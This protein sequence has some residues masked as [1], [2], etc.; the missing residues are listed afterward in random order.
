MVATPRWVVA[1]LFGIQNTQGN[2]QMN[3]YKTIALVAGGLLAVAGT[4]TAAAQRIAEGGYVGAAAGVTDYKIAR[5]YVAGASVYGGWRFNS[6]LAV[7]ASYAD[8]G[9][10]KQE[11][12][13]AGFPV[14]VRGSV[15]RFDVAVQG[16]WP[17][18]D[19]FDLYAKLGVARINYEVSARTA[20]NGRTGYES[21]SGHDN[22]AIYGIGARYNFQSP[23]SL[24]AQIERLDMSDEGNGNDDGVDTLW[25]GAEY[26]FG[27]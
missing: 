7:E 11:V 5:D 2:N 6:W 18:T 27:H 8:L 22:R 3:K 12:W 13:L 15:D 25:I 20:F 1:V 10:S 19:S 23:W 26:R 14:D 21:T 16:I 24:R 4:G 9:E 17:V